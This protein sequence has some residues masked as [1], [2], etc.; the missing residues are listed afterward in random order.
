ML[1]LKIISLALLFACGL[2]AQEVTVNV[3]TAGTLRSMVEAY[4]LS[5]ATILHVKGVL[6]GDDVMVLKSLAGG[7]TGVT[8]PIEGV[9]TALDLAEAHIV[10]GG[11]PYYVSPNPYSSSYPNRCYTQNDT[12]GIFMFLDCKQLTDITLPQ[13]IKGVRESAFFGCSNLTSLTIPEGVT[14][15]PAGMVIGCASLQTLVIPSSTDTVHCY[16]FLN[17]N[18]SCSVWCMA[19]VPP[20]CVD[21]TLYGSPDDP[22]SYS[23]YNAE[24]EETVNELT[25]L[26]PKESYDL[27]SND[28][29][30]SKFGNLQSISL[31][32]MT[33]P[34]LA[35]DQQQELFYR[36]DG[37][38]TNRHSQGI[39]LKKKK[40]EAYYKKY[41]SGRI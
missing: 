40:G 27:Y 20:Q 38:R 21:Y 14:Y 33:H 37:T 29:V 2:H 31:S 23:Y 11:D 26:V 25:L 15:I 6:N 41:V 3:E 4:E 22:E 34:A 39:I 32:S 1:R 16:A 12:I 13:S 9:L 35:P 28:R 17:V 24:F 19:S 10:T 8:N 18:T 30:W 36:I 5:R 7:V